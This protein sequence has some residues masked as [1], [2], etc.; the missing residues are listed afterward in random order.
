MTYRERLADWISGGALTK[1]RV[2]L[3]VSDAAKNVGKRSMRDALERIHAAT[4]N[5]KSGTAQKISRM[6]REGLE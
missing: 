1:A 3:R 5:G 6:A 2:E 4:C